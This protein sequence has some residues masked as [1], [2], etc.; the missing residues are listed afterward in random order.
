ME[1]GG[2]V[3]AQY[4][5]FSVLRLPDTRPCER[6]A[7]KRPTA[8]INQDEKIFPAQQSSR[9][10]LGKT[11]A[12]S[13]ADRLAIPFFVGLTWLTLRLFIYFDKD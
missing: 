12:S 11:Q 9:F 13:T 8:V 4:G 1:D 5:N 10:D 7:W 2:L 3:R 6:S